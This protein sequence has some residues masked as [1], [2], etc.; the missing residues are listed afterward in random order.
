MRIEWPRRTV[1]P[2]RPLPRQVLPRQAL[3]RQERIRAHGAVLL[4][5]TQALEQMLAQ[6][7]PLPVDEVPLDDADGCVLAY[8][9]KALRT[10][11]PADRD[12]MGLRRTRAHNRQSPVHLR[13]IGEM[14]GPFAATVGEGQAARIFTRGLRCHGPTPWSFKKSPRATAIGSRCRNP[15]A[16]DAMSGRRVWIL[17]RRRAARQRSPAHGARS[18]ACRCNEPSAVP[19]YRRPRIALFA[20]GESSPAPPGQEPG[21]GQIVYSKLRLPRRAEGA[22]VIDLGLVHDTIEA[23]SL[24]LPTRAEFPPTW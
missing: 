17:P 4:S 16:R 7:S 23:T 8:D 24:P 21:P 11:P 5:V 20:T 13:V 6:A 9:L 19:V 3:P 22:E 2:L 14:V 10:Q 18:R 1:R 12:G 15:R